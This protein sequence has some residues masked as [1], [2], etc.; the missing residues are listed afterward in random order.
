MDNSIA[1]AAAAA[2]VSASQQN[3]AAMNLIGAFP[4]VSGASAVASLPPH[5]ASQQQQPQPAAAWYSAG[6]S[7]ASAAGIDKPTAIAA[8]AAAPGAPGGVVYGRLIGA[9]AP[10]GDVLSKVYQ[11]QQPQQQLIPLIPGYSALSS[12]QGGHAAAAANHHHPG[13]PAGIVQFQ[14]AQPPA[15]GPS[16][17]ASALQLVNLA[18]AAAAAAAAQ[19]QPQSLPPPPPPQ[20]KP[21]FRNPAN[22]PLRKLSVDLI[23]TYKHI[24]E[25]YYTKKKRRAQQTQ[26]GDGDGTG[27][28]GGGGGGGAGGGGGGGVGGHSHRKKERKLY[29]DGYDDENH[30]YIVKSGERFMDRYEIDSLIGKGSFGQ[31]VKAYDHEQECHVAIKIIKNKKPF[32]HQVIYWLLSKSDG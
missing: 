12:K 30:D 14:Q 18:T 24:N 26:G 4:T 17:D 8:T 2:A 21:Q 32:L 3:A 23:K 28:G 5:L 10:G 7:A 22:A 20:V 1:A 29:N 13:V 9:G 27:A 31:V 11:P 6:A 19:Q 15:V 25:V 16:G